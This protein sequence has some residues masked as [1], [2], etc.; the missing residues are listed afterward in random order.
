M[1][2]VALDQGRPVSAA[3]RLND[4]LGLLKRVEFVLGVNK[5]DRPYH[6][7]RSFA[8][9]CTPQHQRLQRFSLAIPAPFA[10]TAL[11]DRE[12]RPTASHRL[13]GNIAAALVGL[14]PDRNQHAI[15]TLM[16]LQADL[17]QQRTGDLLGF[18][19]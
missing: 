8:G 12:R 17:H 16:A 4:S 1:A 9:E 15:F 19:N 13:N 6:I 18:S 5:I 11:F 10:E 7:K 14:T 3:S 2:T